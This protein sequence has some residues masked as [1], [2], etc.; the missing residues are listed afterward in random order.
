MLI[1]FLFLLALVVWGI[2]VSK[3]DIVSPGIL[4]LFI[5]GFSCFFAI[6][7]ESEWDVDVTLF[8][9]IIQLSCILALV[10]PSVILSAIEASNN[11]LNYSYSI[12]WFKL[13]LTLGYLFISVYL[14]LNLLTNLAFELGYD[15]NTSS[16]SLL[17]FVRFETTHRDDVNVGRL[18]PN[19]L[20]INFALGCITFYLFSYYTFFK[21]ERMKRTLLLIL[22]LGFLFI[23]I[24]SA[25]RTL[26]LSMVIAY[27]VI[28]LLFFSRAKGWKSIKEMKKVLLWLIFVPFLFISLFIFVGVFFLNRFGD[29]SIESVFSNV[30][31]YISS[32][33]VIFSKGIDS[34]EL[35]T[36]GRFGEYTF[37]SLYGTFKSLGLV[38]DIISPFL[39]GVNLGTWTSNV[40]TANF[41][42]II[43]FGY[44]GAML[45][46]FIIGIS[47]GLFYRY[48]KKGGFSFSSVLIYAMLMYGLLMSFFDEQLFFNINN[49]FIRWVYAM[50]CFYLLVSKRKITS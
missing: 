29:G 42:Y 50:V 24:F 30:A 40:Y 11:S 8:S 44:Y 6:F 49:F 17:E 31:M 21:V 26:L 14:I 34:L 41:R 48:I 28:F 15:P 36:N 20:R 32:P 13:F 22:A 25:G 9:I 4:F 23:S 3:F 35:Y 38:K 27:L 43:D 7:L 37:G 47:I 5:W 2:L 39:F 33:L 12:S 10:F 45:I 19:L 18:L 46:N 16:K 1:I